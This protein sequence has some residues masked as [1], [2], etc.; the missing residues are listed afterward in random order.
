LGRLVIVGACCKKSIHTVQ[1]ISFESFEKDFG[2]V[3]TEDSEYDG[4]SA[5]GHFECEVEY[6]LAFFA[7]QGDR[8]PCRTEAYQIIYPAFDIK[9]N[10]LFKRV[11]IY[12]S[13]VVKRGD[14]CCS[15][16]FQFF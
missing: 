8:F 14:E 16:A 5:V 4:N 11:K 13:L 3:G 6:F 10:D 9:L 2:A 1:A 12:F 15:C 7:T